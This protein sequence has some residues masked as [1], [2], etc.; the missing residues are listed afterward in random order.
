MINVIADNPLDLYLKTFLELYESESIKGDPRN[1]KDVSAVLSLDN[2]KLDQGVYL[3]KN[4]FVSNFNYDKYIV[5]GNDWVKVEIDH[6][7]KE[8]IGSGKIDQLV[9]LF[10]YD[11][12]TRRGVISLWDNLKLDLKKAF[13]CTVYAWFRKIGNRLNLNYHMRAGDAYKILL[14][15]IHIGTSLHAYVAKE[16]RLELGSYNH[17]VDSLHFYKEHEKYIE[18]L[19][20]R[21]K[22]YG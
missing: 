20:N 7:D 17:I 1:Y 6:Y 9:K 8:F 19:Y 10:K 12:Y 5:G 22:K 21:L 4:G 14:I 11:P 16:L 2:Y 18:E 3:G 13:P 15:D